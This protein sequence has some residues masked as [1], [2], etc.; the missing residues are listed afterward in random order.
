MPVASSSLM[1]GMSWP[2]RRCHAVTFSLSLVSQVRR[3]SSADPASLMVRASCSASFTS[4]A[5]TMPA[6]PRLIR[7]R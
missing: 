1:S 3:M 5:W 4:L 6:M 7:R 2:C